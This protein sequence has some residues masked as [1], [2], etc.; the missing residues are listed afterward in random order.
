MPLVG[1]AELIENIVQERSQVEHAKYLAMASYMLLIYDIIIRM[2]DEVTYIW[3]SR[4]T[5]ARITYHLNRY[6][7]LVVLPVRRL[8]DDPIGLP[9]IISA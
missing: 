1:D 9:I 6:V 2:D 7:P 8:L 3:S 5:F 4:W